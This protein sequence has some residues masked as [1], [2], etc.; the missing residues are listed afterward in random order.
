M[1]RS[2]TKVADQILHEIEDT[3]AEY[4]PHLLNIVQTFKKA[5][6]LGAAERSFRRAWKEVKIGKTRP[7]AELWDGIDAE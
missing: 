4:L 1:S 3:P 2:S 6:R 7:I 5:A